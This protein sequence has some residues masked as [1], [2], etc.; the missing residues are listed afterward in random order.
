MNSSDRIDV[1]VVEDSPHESELTL[2]ALKK[3]HPS[4]NVFLVE[5]GVQALD[6]L[7]GKSAFAHRANT[8]AP[9][10]VL[11]DFK[12]PKMNGLE[13]LR[14][15]RAN[16]ETKT[17]PV[18]MLTSSQEEKDITDSYEHGA[19]SYLVKPVDFDQFV[20]CV[21]KVGEYWLTCNRLPR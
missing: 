5:D 4:A 12:L 1:L 8:V 10:L 9:R 18:V 3:S 13:V 16:D 20:E 17:I 7:L 15:I 19:N 6:F 2:R 14:Q 21:S 11:L